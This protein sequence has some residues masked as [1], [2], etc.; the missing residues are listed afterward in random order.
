M[1]AFCLHPFLRLEIAVTVY[2]EPTG[3]LTTITELPYREL[4]NEGIR[5]FWFDKD[6]TV[7]PQ[8]GHKVS[9]EYD[10][11]F[12][13]LV[14]AGGKVCFPSNNPAAR[15]GLVTCEHKVFRPRS[16]LEW[17]F[18][19][20]P[21]PRYYRRA[22]EFTGANPNEVVMIG[23][24]YLRDVNGALN[25]GIREAYLVVPMGDR[26]LPLDELLGLR[27][28]EADILWENFGITLPEPCP[29]PTA[30]RAAA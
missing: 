28:K 8:H 30:L 14:A 2:R 21:D 23:D 6:R 9:P 7:V 13:A 26:D 12:Q 17:P 11:F 18:M 24:K 5:H 15:P 20:K 27:Q 22:L 16:Y 1:H 4:M 29:P 19:K 3:I 25:A 10:E